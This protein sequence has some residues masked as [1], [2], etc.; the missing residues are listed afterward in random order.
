MQKK[1]PTVLCLLDLTK[2]FFFLKEVL[3]CTGNKLNTDYQENKSDFYFCMLL[4]S[5]HLQ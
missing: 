1:Q 4:S 2:L 3:L 5:T